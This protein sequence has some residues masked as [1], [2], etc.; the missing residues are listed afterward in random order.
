MCRYSTTGVGGW[1]ES[2]VD[3]GV[4]SQALMYYAQ[5]TTDNLRAEATKS[6]DQEVGSPVYPHDILR[7]AYDAVMQDKEVVAGKLPA[8]GI[9]STCLLTL[10]CNL[11]GSSTAT[12]VTLDGHQGTMR[13]AK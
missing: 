5:K 8:S 11:A 4:F 13:A 12:I 1:S 2:G 3:P 7:S 6:G 9:T 10:C